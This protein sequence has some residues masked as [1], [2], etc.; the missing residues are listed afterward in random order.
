MPLRSNLF[1]G[2][3]R[4]QDCLISDPAHVVF[5][6]RGRHVR[7]I[8]TALVYIEDPPIDQAEIDAERYGRTTAQAVLAYKKARDIINQTYQ[9]MADDIVG[10]MTI[11]ALDDEMYEMQQ[12]PDPPRPRICKHCGSTHIPVVDPN[13]RIGSK[14]Q[15]KDR[16]GRPV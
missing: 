11:K 10:K 5:G 16:H 7:L 9:E 1:A 15:L 14:L 3:K 8:Q 2:N 13:L 4:L 6:Q 12:N